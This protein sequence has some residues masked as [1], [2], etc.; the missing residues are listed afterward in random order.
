[1]RCRGSQYCSA[2]Y[3]KLMRVNALSCSMSRKGNRYDNAMAK[4]FFHSLKVEAIHGETFET[5]EKMRQKV[6]ECADV[7]Y[8]RARRHAGVGYV[9]PLV[10]EELRA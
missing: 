9:S 3:P 6:F 4:N 2:K 5:R 1:M 8:N 10:F 7:D